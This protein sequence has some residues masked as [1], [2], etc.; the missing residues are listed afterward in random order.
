V[1]FLDDLDLASVPPHLKKE[2]SATAQGGTE[3]FA[4][5]NPVVQHKRVADMNLLHTLLHESS[6]VPPAF[7]GL[8]LRFLE[9]FV[10]F[11][12]QKMDDSWPRGAI[13]L[14]KCT[15]REQ[16]QRSGMQSLLVFVYLPF[17][18]AIAR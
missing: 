4:V 16:A 12:S 18:T 7:L 13:V 3:W 1:A 9:L 5:W 6:V 11:V 2:S 10:A 17:T 15:T 14:H 8:C